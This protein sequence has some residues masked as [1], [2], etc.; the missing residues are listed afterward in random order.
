MCV[1]QVLRE[2]GRAKFAHQDDVFK[3]EEEVHAG[4]PLESLGDQEPQE[5]A[6]NRLFHINKQLLY[7]MLALCDAPGHQLAQDATRHGLLCVYQHTCDLHRSLETPV[8][9]KTHCISNRRAGQQVCL[10]QISRHSH[11]AVKVTRSAK[12]CMQ[13]LVFTHRLSTLVLST[14]SRLLFVHG[15]TLHTEDQG[16]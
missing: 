7:W 11:A 9:L 10:V 6:V 3:S 8:P 13:R 2:A 1:W 12:Q 15:V 14:Y 5:G 4:A 16:S